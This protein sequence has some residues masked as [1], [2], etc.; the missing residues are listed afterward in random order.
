LFFTKKS[1]TKPDRCA[2]ALSWKR[3]RLLVLHFPGS[4]LLVASP[5]RRRISM[6][7]SLFTVAFPLNHT[8]EF[9]GVFDA[10]KYVCFMYVTYAWRSLYIM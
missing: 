6:Y 2:G 9:R 4:F 10:I 3:K 1:L 7:L 8:N 5:Q